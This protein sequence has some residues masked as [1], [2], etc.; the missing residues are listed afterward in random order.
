M[1]VSSSYV[2]RRPEVQ[3][4]TSTYAPGW[5][6]RGPAALMPHHG[7]RMATASSWPTSTRPQAAAVCSLH[8]WVA[9]LAAG[10][11]T[12]DPGWIDSAPVFSPDRRSL[13]FVRTLSILDGDVLCCR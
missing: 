10:S 6:S 3:A 1:P 12:P 5:R 13:A 11:T 7:R 8:H 9:D 4:T 2:G